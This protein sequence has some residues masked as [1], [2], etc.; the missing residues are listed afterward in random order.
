MCLHFS[1]VYS[2]SHYPSSSA[3]SLTFPD[4]F[5]T[6]LT[7]LAIR[8][9]SELRRVG[10]NK[11][12]IVERKPGNDEREGKAECMRLG[13]AVASPKGSAVPNK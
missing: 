2:S 10:Q 12:E 4:V 7:V 13:R 11:R 5:Q 6:N 8:H 3:K 1:S 9:V